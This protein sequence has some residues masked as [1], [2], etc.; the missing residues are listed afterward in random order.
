MFVFS[1]FY[2]STAN[3][4]QGGWQ[5]GRD[6]LQHSWEQCWTSVLHLVFCQNNS[7][8]MS[9]LV[10][11]WVPIL[12]PILRFYTRADAI[13]S[14]L[15]LPHVSFPFSFSSKG[16]SKWE[17]CVP[18]INR[19]LSSFVLLMRFSVQKSTLLKKKKKLT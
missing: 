5:V 13:C 15:P 11:R 7:D 8:S 12:Y 14:F 19:L 9:M 3:V 10:R 2:I 16:S 1:H 6:M 18:G 4:V 17:V